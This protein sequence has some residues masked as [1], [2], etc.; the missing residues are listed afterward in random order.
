[1]GAK[2]NDERTRTRSKRV[3]GRLSPSRRRRLVL[4][5]VEQVTSQPDGRTSRVIAVKTAAKVKKAVSDRL[6]RRRRRLVDFDR[7]P[8]DIMASFHESERDILARERG[9][10]EWMARE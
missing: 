6:R 3:E 8:A 2:T 7:L 10:E 4:F 9:R 5:F 1:M